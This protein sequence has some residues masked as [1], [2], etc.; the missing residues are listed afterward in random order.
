MASLNKA[1]LSGDTL[2]KTERHDVIAW[3]KLAK[4]CGQYL[5][6]GEAPKLQDKLT[7]QGQREILPRVPGSNDKGLQPLQKRDLP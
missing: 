5:S 4:V 6:K 2:E 1:I 7:H 3:G